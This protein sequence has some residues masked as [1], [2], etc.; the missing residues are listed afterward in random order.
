MKLHESAYCPEQPEI[1]IKSV[2]QAEPGGTKA[3]SAL[4]TLPARVY[5]AEGGA[6]VPK[7]PT[8]AFLDGEG[9]VTTAGDLSLKTVTRS[10]STAGTPPSV[11]LNTRCRKRASSP[12]PSLRYSALGPR[13]RDPRARGPGHRRAGSVLRSGRTAAP[14]NA[15]QRQQG[16]D[17]S[18]A[19]P[20]GWT[21]R[22]PRGLKTAELK[23]RGK[24]GNRQ[25]QKLGAK[26]LLGGDVAGL[27]VILP[28]SPGR[29][30]D[31]EYRCRPYR[32]ICEESGTKTLLAIAIKLYVKCLRFER[33]V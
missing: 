3:A 10:L 9:G 18:H 24:V 31:T 11:P 15:P 19:R 20:P 13:T 14:R 21:S 23:T 32:V 12:G 17:Q 25:T 22:K 4:W 5:M 7:L 2:Y 6:S 33:N 16:A 30:Q 27:V 26:W 8:G 1:Q 29:H 28:S